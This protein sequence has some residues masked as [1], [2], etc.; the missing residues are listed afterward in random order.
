MVSG[1]HGVGHS[2]P[3]AY[4][5]S[6]KRKPRSPAEVVETYREGSGLHDH[7]PIGPT[8]DVGT[9]RAHKLPPSLPTPKPLEDKRVSGGGGQ[10]VADVFFKGL[11]GLM[12]KASSA[13]TQPPAAAERPGSLVSLEE[14]VLPSSMK[15]RISARANAEMRKVAEVGDKLMRVFSDRHGEL[16]G[17]LLYG[18]PKTVSLFSEVLDVY[19]IRKAFSLMGGRLLAADSSAARRRGGISTVV[20]IGPS[21]YSANSNLLWRLAN[22]GIIMDLGTTPA[23]NNQYGI[24]QSPRNTAFAKLIYFLGN[25]KI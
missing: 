23:G 22:E 9:E 13:L 17:A 14:S 25:K 1:A 15:K 4:H 5:T 24:L 21:T 7:Q 16:I 20:D 2:R 11:L 12:Q 8:V 19:A 18:G 3:I 10:T 6:V